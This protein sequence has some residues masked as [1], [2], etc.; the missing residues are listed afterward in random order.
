M[1]EV[2]VVFACPVDFHNAPCTNILCS[3]VDNIKA[4]NLRSDLSNP[5]YVEERHSCKVLCLSLRKFTVL[6]SLQTCSQCQPSPFFT[7][8]YV[9]V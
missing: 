8:D 9:C 2:E 4:L 5:Y 6:H 7:L 1:K 3:D